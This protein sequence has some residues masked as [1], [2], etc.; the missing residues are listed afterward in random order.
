MPF[1]FLILITELCL[2][3]Q[4]GGVTS[5]PDGGQHNDNGPICGLLCVEGAFSLLDYKPPD[6]TRL[7]SPRYLGS[8]NGSSAN[9]LCQAVSAFGL[10]AD[11]KSNLTITQLR[12]A[13]L[14]HSTRQEFQRGGIQPLGVVRRI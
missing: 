11:A 10:Y 2:F 12:R 5:F 14:P 9:E 4:L 1:K 6:R 13:R 8:E 7:Y 3:P